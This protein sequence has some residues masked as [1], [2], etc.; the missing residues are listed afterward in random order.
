MADPD[1]SVS[2]ATILTQWSALIQTR[3]QELNDQITQI[4]RASPRQR[5]IWD[6]AHPN[7]TMNMMQNDLSRKIQTLN[8]EE[9]LLNNT[10]NLIRRNNHIQLSTELQRQ[11]DIHAARIFTA[12]RAFQHDHGFAE[13]FV[14]NPED[15]DRLTFLQKV[16]HIIHNNESHPTLAPLPTLE[17][18]PE[19]VIT[20]PPVSTSQPP[21]TPP[22][23]MPTPITPTRSDVTRDA[24]AP[25]RAPPSGG[26][27]IVLKDL[28][29]NRPCATAVFARDDDASPVEFTGASR[30]TSFTPADTDTALNAYHFFRDHHLRC[31]KGDTY[32]IREALRS[33]G[34]LRPRWNGAS[35]QWDITAIRPNTRADWETQW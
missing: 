25:R 2:P 16:K 11:V 22:V 12:K 3:K 32:Q 29:A 8:E 21:I 5:Q 34:T 27:R 9:R 28:P 20:S 30:N 23:S 10:Q 14:S 35:T 4:R 31:V 17:L 18:P 6:E 1:P 7:Q 13:P 15:A 19:P 26:L 33:M 24:P